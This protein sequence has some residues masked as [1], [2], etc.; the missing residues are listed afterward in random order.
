M[1]GL[2]GWLV[3]GF[4][5]VVGFGDLVI[6]SM[7]LFRM[8]F[9]S[10]AKWMGA[11]PWFQYVLAFQDAL[12][13]VAALLSAIYWLRNR[14]TRS[15]MMGGGFVGAFGCFIG[16]SHAPIDRSA[17]GGYWFMYGLSLLMIVLGCSAFILDWPKAK[18]EMSRSQPM[19]C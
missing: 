9:A 7:G 1:R 5:L 16:P 19:D 2:G 3:L 18:E 4:L 14:S 8:W 6:A 10:S 17:I 11:G 13:G 15:A 12:V